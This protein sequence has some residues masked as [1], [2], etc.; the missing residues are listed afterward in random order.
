MKE[1]TGELTG[2]IV[3]VVSVAILIA[4]FYYVIWPI[5]D[6]NFKS[7]TACSKAKCST[8]IVTGKKGF[9]YC[10]YKG[11]TVECPYKG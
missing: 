5:M 3:V 2:T 7:Q 6:N 10:N 8:Q 1:A 9:V 4:F 11:Q